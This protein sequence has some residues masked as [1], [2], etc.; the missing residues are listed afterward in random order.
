MPR[1]SSAKFRPV[2]LRLETIA[3]LER[4][5]EVLERDAEQGRYNPPNLATGKWDTHISLDAVVQEAVRR[6]EEHLD[7]SAVSAR[8]VKRATNDSINLA[9][10]AA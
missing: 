6:W 10:N 5:R 7:R 8:T 2:R 1:P 4:L 9:T 3:R